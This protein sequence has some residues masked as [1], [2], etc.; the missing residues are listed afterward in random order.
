[1]RT[2]YNQ[3]L[4]WLIFLIGVI[5][6][7]GFWLFESAMHTYY[8]DHQHFFYALFPSDPNELSMR[9]TIFGLFIIFGLIAAWVTHRTLQLKQ[10]LSID[11]IALT[12]IPESV[13]IT[14]ANNKII[15]V[16]RAYTEVTGYTFDEVK[17]KNPSVAS[18]GKQDKAFY[19]TLWTSLQQTGRWQ[20]ELWNR[21]KDGEL[22]PE[23][24]SI[25]VIKDKH[26]NITNHIAI[27]SD[28]TS[29]KAAEETIK[30]YAYYDPLTDL[31]NRRFFLERV[32][33]AIQYAKRN[34]DKLAVM[35]IDLDHF[36][37][38]NDTHGHDI[39]DLYL[40]AFTRTVKDRLREVDT[41][42]RFGG[43]EFVI[44]LTSINDCQTA[45]TIA[46]KIL[47]IKS[48]TA[49][50]QTLSVSCSIGIACYPD[51]GE[52]TEALITAADKAMYQ[53]KQTNR[54]AAKLVT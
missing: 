11:Q 48:I 43:D 13:V 28:I 15:F 45:L 44:L 5:F 37:Q 10:Q 46:E 17:G 12:A 36:K 4:P 22:Y 47:A 20:G 40:C 42:S 49:G 38:I 2:T 8:F 50:D 23:W 14:D 16:N 24:L 30:H 34:K 51:H 3:R 31:P 32:S 9:C 27:F 26:K 1:M 19:K 52:D 53:I 25:S 29:R 21:R 39:G 35:F 7:M 6:A 18:S 33:Q 54:N 41:L